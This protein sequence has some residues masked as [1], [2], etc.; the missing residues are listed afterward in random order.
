MGKYLAWVII[1]AVALIALFILLTFVYQRGGFEFID[2]ETTQERV[3]TLL[4]RIIY[5]FTVWFFLSLSKKVL[6]PATIIAVSP[7]LGKIVNNPS[8]AKKF[9][10]SLT[11]YL[12]YIVYFIVIC[13]FIIIW[14]YDIVGPWVADLLGSSLIIM[15][16]FIL[17]LFSSSVLGNILGYAIIGGTHELKAGDRIQIDDIHGDVIDVGFFFTHIKTLRDEII[18]VPNLTVMNKEIHNFSTLKK[19]ALHVQVTLGYDVDKDHAQETLI[20]A[21]RKTNGILSLPDKEPF[22]LLRELGSYA[23]T[24]ELNAYTD[25][26]NRL[27]QVKSELIS[28]MLVELKKAGIVIATPTIITIKGE[29]KLQT[30][31]NNTKTQTE[32]P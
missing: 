15:L 32:Q 7:A 17:G 18:S 26:P 10:K 8:A 19:V 27:A 2:S 9:N 22:V 25:E 30:T 11:Q 28:N 6:I 16:T 29:E 21:A 31:L 14:I 12:T 13:T 3:Y 23:I 4:Q 24:Y 20:E 5:S 1:R